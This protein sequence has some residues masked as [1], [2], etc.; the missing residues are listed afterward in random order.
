MASRHSLKNKGFTLIEMSLAFL[1]FIIGIYLITFSYYNL[2]RSHLETQKNQIALSNLRLALDKVWL[3]LK[4]GV[5][6]STSTDCLQF[7][8]I[9]DCREEIIC[10]RNNN[11]ELSLE[12]ATTTLLNPDIIVINRFSYQISGIQD[13]NSDNYIS[14]SPKLITISISGDSRVSPQKRIP[15]VFQMS[16][17]PINSVFPKPKC[18][19]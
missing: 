10:F 14:K 6:F 16:V 1:V 12:G 18:V 9:F 5:G 4:Y 13:P 17:A 7:R 11:L 2:V 19:E 3:D 15:F 8:R